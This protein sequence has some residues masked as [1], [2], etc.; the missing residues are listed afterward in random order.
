MGKSRFL[1][2]L[3]LLFSTILFAKDVPKVLSGDRAFLLDASGILS[4]QQKEAIQSKLKAY[5]DSTSTQIAVLIEPSLEGEDLFEY[6]FKVAREWGIGEKDKDNGILIY[7][8][9]ADRKTYIQIGDG[10]EGAI[11]DMAAGRVI[12]YVMLPAFKSGDYYKGIDQ[13]IDELILYASGEHTNT[14]RPKNG[15]PSWLI[16]IIIIILLIIFTSFGSNMHKTYGDYRPNLGRGPYLGGGWLGGG[17]SGGFG[18]GGGGGFGGFGGGG[19]SGGGAG[20]SW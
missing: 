15:F 18:G 3:M 2:V 13:A 9:T 20:G 1:L 11:P 5:F 16:V 10:L 6:S 12:D 17:S 8:A 4:G 14:G 7:I 19:F